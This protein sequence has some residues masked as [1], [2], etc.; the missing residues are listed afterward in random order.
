MYVYSDNATY[1]IHLEFKFEDPESWHLFVVMTEPRLGNNRE[2]AQ[3]LV[4]VI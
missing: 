3:A 1:Y 4:L 2:L